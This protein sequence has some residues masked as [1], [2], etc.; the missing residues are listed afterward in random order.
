[1]AFAF[2]GCAKDIIQDEE[3]IS[4]TSEIVSD[5]VSDMAILESMGFSAENIEVFD[6]YYLVEGDIRFEK[7][8]MHLYKVQTRQYRDNNL[9][10]DLYQ[11]N[12]TVKIDAT[13]IYYSDWEEAIL[14][15]INAWNTEPGCNLHMTYVRSGNADITIYR[16][17]TFPPGSG[18]FGGSSPPL[19][20]GKPGPHIYV[21][22]LM[23]HL[24]KGAKTYGIMHELGHTVGLRHTDYILQGE[25]GGQWIPGT[26][27]DNSDQ[28]TLMMSEY[29]G[30]S[31]PNNSFSNDDKVGLRNIYPKLYWISYNRQE[32]GARV[33]N[34]ASHIP[35][36][37]VEWSNPGGGLIYSTKNGEAHV[38]GG[39]IG[40]HVLQAKIYLTSTK[41]V[42]MSTGVKFSPIQITANLIVDGQ[43]AGTLTKTLVSYTGYNLKDVFHNDLI[44]NT[45]INLNNLYFQGFYYDDI[46]L[47]MNSE[48]YMNWE[49]ESLEMKYSTNGEVYP[50][51]VMFGDPI[52][53]V[54]GL[55]YDV[56]MWKKSPSQQVTYIAQINSVSQVGIDYIDM[57]GEF[58]AD[59]I[60][61][62][63]FTPTFYDPVVKNVM[64]SEIL[65][66]YTSINY[67]T[68]YE[69]MIDINS[70]LCVEIPLHAGTMAIN[71][72]Q[73]STWY[74]MGAHGGSVGFDS[75]IG[76]G[77][78]NQ[79]SRKEKIGNIWH[80]DGVPI[81]DP[82]TLIDDQRDAILKE[83][84]RY[85]DEKLKKAIATS[86]KGLK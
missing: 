58:T 35:I 54:I 10:S 37:R 31:Y 73:K 64:V 39:S 18:T 5:I 66:D 17:W 77:S 84:V 81:I 24:S 7:E 65:T 8:N 72:Y 67:K 34:L 49:N 40:T 27:K 53:G 60:M 70:E 42:I 46:I 16:D 79:E 33:Y 82:G 32:N 71:S 57:T 43:P 63:K 62:L 2:M 25:G 30:Q 19:N 26:F 76:K 78:F 83:N 28:S 80:I 74:G 56:K 20:N 86:K 38:K 13:L 36:T 69:Q 14:D 45:G 21:N 9:V 23:D 61:I 47:P 48:N 55:V 41:Y 12:I 68:L 29:S 59:D 6:D 4:D 50:L 85:Y 11:P 52:N 44:V 51:L 75:V 3:Q 15:A 22:A 1:M